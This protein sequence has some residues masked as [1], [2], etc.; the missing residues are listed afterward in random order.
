M[1]KTWEVKSLQTRW[2]NNGWGPKLIFGFDHGSFHVASTLS[3]AKITRKDSL[4]ANQIHYRQ[5]INAIG[6][7]DSL[8]TWREEN[9]WG[10]SWEKRRFLPTTGV[11]VPFK[12]LSSE[13]QPIQNGLQFFNTS[14]DTYYKIILLFWPFVSPLQMQTVDVERRRRR[15]RNR[16]YNNN[17]DPPTWF[18]H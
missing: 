18:C 4:I 10:P 15:R 11:V 1:S 7:V 6:Y 8:Q 5:W 17:I 3:S 12:G 14:I 9:G 16:G 13:F 2:E